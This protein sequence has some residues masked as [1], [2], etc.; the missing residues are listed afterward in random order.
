MGCIQ[1]SI[2]WSLAQQYTVPH[3]KPVGAEKSSGMGVQA[4]VLEGGETVGGG[5]HPGGHGLVYGEHH[6]VAG[7]VVHRGPCTNSLSL[8]N[9]IFQK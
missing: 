8:N 6:L 7:T 4:G 9:V 3:H 1:G 5:S 2:N